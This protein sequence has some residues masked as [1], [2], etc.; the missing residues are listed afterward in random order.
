MGDRLGIP[1]VVGLPFF[2]SIHVFLV[3]LVTC[4]VSFFVMFVLF[5]LGG[6]G[7]IFLLGFLVFSSHLQI[8]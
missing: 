7:D 4:F 3:R 1:S 6:E 8:V 2:F 5:F